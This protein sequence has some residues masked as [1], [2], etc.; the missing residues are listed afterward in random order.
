MIAFFLGALH[1]RIA[2]LQSSALRSRLVAYALRKYD[3]IADLQFRR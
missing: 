2:G 3:A 1:H